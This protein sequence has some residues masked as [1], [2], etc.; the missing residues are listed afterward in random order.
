MGTRIGEAAGSH[1]RFGWELISRVQNYLTGGSFLKV[2]LMAI[3]A[4]THLSVQT[5]AQTQT[6]RL[7]GTVH[8]AS[9]AVIPNAK[10]TATQEDTSKTTATT[11]TSTGE[12]VLPALQPGTYSLA[13]EAAGFR[14]AVIDG[15]RVGRRL[16]HEPVRHARSRPGDR[17]IRSQG[18]RGRVQTTDAQV[19]QSV[20]LSDIATL[21][22]L[23]RTPITLAI[24]QPGVQINPQANGSSERRRL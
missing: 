24:F 2:T 9:G 6:A 1:F 12:Y 17:S 19:S 5:F 20:T 4:L 10:V 16:E 15:A 13:V 23:S 8:D 22:Q 18:Q 11:A 3:S 7:V 21:P 14:R